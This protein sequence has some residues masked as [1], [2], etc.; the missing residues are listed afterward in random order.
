MIITVN[1]SCQTLQANDEG[2]K[3]WAKSVYIWK[4]EIVFDQNWSAGLYYILALAAPASTAAVVV[5]VYM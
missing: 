2:W 5:V 3:K 1:E 4:F